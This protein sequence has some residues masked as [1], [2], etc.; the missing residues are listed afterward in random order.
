MAK[1]ANSKE[2]MSDYIAMF[3]AP[4]RCVTKSKGEGL[5]GY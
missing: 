3:I 5:K 1:S 4:T 2:G